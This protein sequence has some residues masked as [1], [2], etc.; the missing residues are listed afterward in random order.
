MLTQDKC[1]VILPDGGLCSKL[2]CTD[3]RV[4]QTPRV[5]YPK[6]VW[7]RLERQI[8]DAT[9]DKVDAEIAYLRSL[10]DEIM[11]DPHLP[12]DKRYSLAMKAID[13]VVKIVVERDRLLEARQF[14]VSRS[15]LKVLLSKLYLI[16]CR[17]VKD[18]K[19]RAQI[20]KDIEQL[21]ISGHSMSKQISSASKY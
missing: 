6:S 3:H 20:G 4:L 11:E 14:V 10:V 12:K 1:M 2:N 8:E 18:D 19:K 7:D 16:I 21:Q 15:Y 9:L 13:L 17:H 5:Y